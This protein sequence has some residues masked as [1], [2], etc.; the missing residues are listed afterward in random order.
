M[1]RSYF[2]VFSGLCLCLTFF[3]TA[4]AEIH[5]IITGSDEVIPLRLSVSPAIDGRLDEDV[6][7]SIPIS[8]PFMTYNPTYGE[9]LPQRTDVWIAYDDENLYF[10]FRCYDTE[11]GEIKTSITQRDNMFSDD[12]VGIALDA[13]GTSQ[14]R[15]DL[16]VNPNGIQGDILTSA[17][18]GED[19]APDFVWE[20]AGRLT[21]QGYEVEMKVPLRSIRFKSGNEVTMRILF[22]RRISRLGTSGSWPE[23]QP[24]RSLFHIQ[25]RVVYQDLKNPLVLEVLPSF[26]YSSSTDRLTPSKWG[27]K[28]ISRDFGVGLKYGL[29]SSVTAE[30]TYNPDFSQV[31]SDAFQAEFNRRYP[32]FY[33][34]KR[35]FF[36]EGLDIFD[37][38]IIG[39]GLIQTTLHTRR[40]VDPLW[41]SK[42]TG[43]VGRAAVGLLAASDEGPGYYREGHLNPFEGESAD[44][45]VGRGKLSLG[46]DDYIGGLFSRRALSDSLNSV[47]GGDAQFRFGGNHQTSFSLM[48][49]L[50][51][52]PNSDNRD[53]TS[54]NWAWNY[55]SRTF[56]AAAAYQ[57]IGGDFLMDSAFLLRTGVDNGWIWL[58]PSFY[59]DPERHYWLRRISPEF[60]YSQLYDHRTKQRDHYYSLAANAFFSRQGNLRIEYALNREGWQGRSFWEDSYTVNGGVQMWRWLGF[61]GSLSW[62]ESIYYPGS[63]SYLGYALTWSFG[64]NLQPSSKF[65]Q[66]FEVFHEDFHRSS[67]DAFIYEVNIFNAMTTYQFNRYFF[68]RGIVQYNS[69]DELLLTDFLA[70][71][72]FIPGTVLH[73]G[74]GSL[75]DRREWLKDQSQWSLGEGSLREI[76]RGLFFKASY[77]WRF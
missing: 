61:G 37:F 1:A 8:R 48:H 63:P 72:T 20:S 74:Y 64:F 25:A 55:G 57:H 17:V 2:A 53:G 46:G 3:T 7:Q 49:S 58:S 34:E 11:P 38:S 67:D 76:H 66:S 44:F 59:P 77:L 42:I 39:H 29:T 75:Y 9:E 28:D 30:V 21:D 69:F 65:N 23:I 5:H 6:W 50:T 13:L 70:S 35:P 16:F 73:L 4:G 45:L 12:W 41:G 40:I 51:D 24:G 71:F 19:L 60:V 52:G 47:V 32:V 15:Y 33:E 31:E 22:W 62:H 26:T 68:V 27:Y 10:A 43:T 14:T 36:M 18:S 54:L 56:G